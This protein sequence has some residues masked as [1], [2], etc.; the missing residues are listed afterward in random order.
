MSVVAIAE[1]EKP[2]DKPTMPVWK[3]VWRVIYFKRVY[4]AF[5]LLF[6]VILMLA[7]QIPSL[8]LR[9]F[10]NLVTNEATVSLTLPMIIFALFLG[11]AVRVAGFWGLIHT[12]VPFF[13]Y[14]CILLRQNILRHVLR[15]PGAR[16]LP[17]SPGEAV[18]RF[19]GDVE[20][21]GWVAL[22]VNDILGMLAFN[23]VSLAIMLSISVPITLLVMLPFVVVLLIARSTTDKIE[24]YRRA[25][26]KYTGMVSG[27]IGEMFGAVQA[28]KVATAEE[29][30]VARFRKMNDERRTVAIKDRMF[31]EVLHSLFV[32][33]VNIGTGVILIVAA[34]AIRDG[35]FTVGDFALFVIYLEYFSDMTAFMGLIFARYRQIGVSVERMTRLMDGA[36]AEALVEYNP[37][38]LEG[39]FPQTD[40]AKAT[41]ADNL[42]LLEV[43]NL[44][45]Q[46]PDSEN[47]IKDIKLRLERG[48]FT[49][50]TGRVGSGKTTLVRTLLGLLGKDEGEIRWNGSLVE[51]PDDF[52]IAPRCSYTAQV[53]RLF[54]DPLR[55]NI[56]LGLRKTDEQIV[57]AIRS[58]V[59]EHDLNELDK[60]FDTM[61]GPKGVKLSGGQIQRTAA[62]RMFT[63]DTQLL[64]FDDLSSA[65]D[66][67]TEKTLW[68]RVFEHPEISCLVVSHRKAALRHADH[69]IVLK[70]GKIESEGTL[71][72]LLQNSAEFRELW[73]GDGNSEAK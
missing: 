26:R 69:I 30:V 32:N 31:N 39:E 56:L 12:N 36:P 41:E 71:D 43:E 50:I 27:F 62:A 48:S 55:D 57:P 24:E 2:K 13:N 11:E 17:D 58:A 52:F 72:E 18:S 68:E 6:M 42:N 63:R 23:L 53:P 44:N 20:E 73:A 54:S 3:L 70:D 28:I 21:I 8:A 16:A 66:V 35:S 1:N 46:Y 29:G 38:Y 51:R 64:V 9:E 61:V 49:V 59:M 34:G 37:V 60:G 4:F 47:G 5:N 33:S 45:Y 22:W 10:F 19:R 7:G 15:R 40:Y 65:L 14:V 67:E 25:S